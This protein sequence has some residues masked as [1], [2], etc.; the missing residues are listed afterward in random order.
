MKKRN[1]DT[2]KSVH[3]TRIDTIF[4]KNDG[5][6][7]SIYKDQ[8]GNGSYYIDEYD[9]APTI[10]GFNGTFATDAEAIAAVQNYINNIG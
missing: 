9:A 7:Y 8:N 3:V 6:P 10:I 4:R 1:F 2:G 5:E